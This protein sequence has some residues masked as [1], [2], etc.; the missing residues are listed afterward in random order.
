ML[1]IIKKNHTKDN[2]CCM[3]YNDRIMVLVQRLTIPFEHN[4][5]MHF[6]IDFVCFIFKYWGN[7]SN[8]KRIINNN[9]KGHF[10]DLAIRPLLTIEVAQ[11]GILFPLFLIKHCKTIISHY[12]CFRSLLSGCSPRLF[13]TLATLFTLHRINPCLNLITIANNLS[14]IE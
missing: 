9:S 7:P 5:R 2:E 1:I 6:I 8:D 10:Q 13:S 11:L 4:K 14:V 12:Y 3:D